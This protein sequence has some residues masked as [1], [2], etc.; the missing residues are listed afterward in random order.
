MK[1]NISSNVL[2]LGIALL[3]VHSVNAQKEEPRALFDSLALSGGF[4]SLDLRYTEVMG[5]NAVLMGFGLGIVVNDNF[6]IGLAGAFNTSTI[7]NERYERFLNDSLQVNTGGGLEMNY[8]YGG[9]LLERVFFHRSPV[10]FSVPV[11]IGLGG[12]NYGYPLPNSNSEN[13]NKVA[14]QAFFALEPGLQLEATIIQK[15]RIGLGASYLY[16]SDLDLP[17]TAPDALR[18]VM[19]RLTLRYAAP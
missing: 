13:R 5:T 8:G 3:T 18:T 1:R 17:E 19:Y 14:G 10:H 9:L 4:F 15:F 7:K 2:A 6:N 11:L 16:T 12:I